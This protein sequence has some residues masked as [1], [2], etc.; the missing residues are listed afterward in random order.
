MS[1]SITE[2]GSSRSRLN[3]S[4]LALLAAFPALPALAQ[5]IA[6]PDAGQVLRDLRPS[7]ENAPRGNITLALPADADTSADTGL[8]FHVREIR[9]QGMQQIDEATLHA[10]VAPLE[11]G[12]T[13]LGGL[14]QA[15]QR[16]TQFYRQRGFIVARAFVPA[17]Q[18]T[19]GVVTIAVL[20]SSMASYRLDNRSTV[21]DDAMS[22]VVDAQ[23]MQ[24]QPIVADRM[25]RTLLLLADLPGVGNVNGDL[26]PGEK[27]GTSDLVIHA[28]PGK[29]IEGD[30]SVDNYG[31]RFTGQNR[32]NA[33]LTFNNLNHAG[34]RLDLRG[35]GSNQDLLSGR[36]AYDMP[37]SG[38]GLRGGLA[39]SS[40]RYELGRE[41]ANLDANGTAR[42]ASAY[43]SYPLLRG[44]NQ[45]VWFAG[46]LE[47]RALRDRV[48]LISSQT[49]KQARVATLEAY[50]D[51][52]DS[53]GGGG[54]NTWRIAGTGGQLDIQTPAAEAIDAA[55]PRAAGG[56]GKLQLA[57]SRLQSLPGD[58][59]L[60][61]QASG[62]VAH[63]NL[64]SSEKFVTGGAYGVRAYPQGEG[65]G[66]DG[67]LLN[68]ELR[69]SIV[70]GLQ[71]SVF[72]DA[73]GARFSHDA[74]ATGRNRETLRG[75]GFGL[76]GRWKE[77]YGQATIAW[78]DGQ[79]PLTA[80]DRNPR[81]WLATG[82]RF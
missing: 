29:S 79:A 10:L 23:S 81:L 31:N 15:A 27:V 7:L 63:K 53:L 75:Y 19:D 16:I 77:F 41:F 50:G 37:L 69:R 12:E 33:H 36:A 42:T 43:A 57:A 21:R 34:D 64:D 4:I 74:Y 76:Q 11:G 6:P 18:L 46:S 9:L 71:A 20:E 13:T 54:Y 28:E 48:G 65:V 73:G 14:R 82:W 59:T 24:D 26:K 30:F 61:V 17:Q 67:W 49:D 32:A 47:Y 39:L 52:A 2:A 25:D 72:Y 56:Y 35:T 80:P 51:L 45:N 70:P 55:G 40:T 44:I 3:L 66:D 68:V 60:A 5:G 62:Q 8:R 78:R 22:R 1:I 58:F 38:N